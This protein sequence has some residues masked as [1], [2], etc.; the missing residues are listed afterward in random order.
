MKYIEKC[1]IKDFNKDVIVF[2]RIMPS[3]CLDGVLF[4]RN[5]MVEKY[6]L[7]KN[8]DNVD[9]YKDKK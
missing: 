3:Y 7:V 2:I 6:G 1:N 8:K 9:F 4:G 5:Y